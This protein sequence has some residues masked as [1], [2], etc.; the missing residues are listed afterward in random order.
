MLFQISL[1]LNVLSLV[2]FFVYAFKKYRSIFNAGTYFAIAGSLILFIYLCIEGM[3]LKR[4]PSLIPSLSYSFLALLIYI[5]Y[6]FGVYKFN[7]RLLGSFMLPAAIVLQSLSIIYDP[8]TLIAKGEMKQ[9]FVHFYVTFLFLGIALFFFSFAT[10]IMYMM[11][12]K[13]LKMKRFTQF[14]FR[15]PSLEK[16]E[17]MVAFGILSGYPIV[18]S[19]I[20]IGIVGYKQIWGVKWYIQPSPILIFV[21]WLI[22][23]WI[24]F[25]RITKKFHGK[26]FALFMILGAS[27]IILSII[28]AFCFGTIPGFSFF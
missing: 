13:N 3:K 21:M 9:Y 18:T 23:S 16:I 5:I 12:E 1:T 15:M 14:Y 7:I 24:F 6:F 26:R 20:L 11:Q 4:C 19:A 2:F 25:K 28:I 17:E 27:S 10:A 8:V 22:F